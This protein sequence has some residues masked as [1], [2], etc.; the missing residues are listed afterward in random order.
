MNKK[1]AN[2]CASKQSAS[3]RQQG[4]NESDDRNKVLTQA[5][6]TIQDNLC[7]TRNES[8]A[9]F[10]TVVNGEGFETMAVT[11][12]RFSRWLKGLVRDQL[13]K[14]LPKP[15]ITELIEDLLE[16]GGAAH[17]EQVNVNC[18]VLPGKNGQIFID[19]CNPYKHVI[20]VTADG[21][22]VTSNNDDLQEIPFFLR[23]NGM[24]AL[25]NPTSVIGDLELL[26]K[27]VNLPSKQA[28][29]LL[30]TYLL[31]CLRPSGPYVILI[32][33]G[34]AGS[35]KST[36]SRVI[37]SLVDPSSVPTQAIPKST[38]DLTITASHS[39]LLVFDNVG[40]L[41][42]EMSDALCRM[43]TGGGIRTRALY[44]NDEE[45]LFNVKKPCILNGISDIASQPDLLSRCI[46][47]DLPVIQGDTRRTEAEFDRSFEEARPVIFAGLMDALSKTLAALPMITEKPS[48]RMADFS[49]W[50]C[51]VELALDWPKGSFNNAYSKNM[52]DSMS[53]A[54]GDDPLV[55]AIMKFIAVHVGEEDTAIGTPTQMLDTLSTYTRTDQ[56]SAKLWPKSPHALSKRLKKL[57]PALL[58]C[59]VKIEFI[60]S[61]NRTI[62]MSR[63]TGF[64]GNQ[65]A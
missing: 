22:A 60:H 34:T 53:D 48:T 24:T 29:Y 28:W 56:Q 63:L 8:N 58:A 31:F 18:R 32:I 57:E 25:P 23:P 38:A 26:R 6:Q 55:D 35:C 36:F 51:A 21:Y 20:E 59:R 64:T 15:M 45:V 46:Y 52:R 11:S 10:A 14:R 61:G 19:L 37:R 13:N 62:E 42:K 30:V 43:A 65:I 47:F 40:Q 39:H 3:N 27:F 49:Q 54:L 7:L 2:E 33:A 50:G 44:S 16:E 9:V 4:S 1:S 17:V 12:T 5:L 41:S